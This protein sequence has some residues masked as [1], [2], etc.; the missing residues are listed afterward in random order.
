MYVKYLRQVKVKSFKV[1]FE[2]N[3]IQPFVGA[4][5]HK[6]NTSSFS[7]DDL[8]TNFYVY[9]SRTSGNFQ[10]YISILN[11]MNELEFINYFIEKLIRTFFSKF[12]LSR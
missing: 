2:N 11:N 9:I 4:N 8:C 10:L 1:F 12:K 3:F 7:V 5:V 6:P